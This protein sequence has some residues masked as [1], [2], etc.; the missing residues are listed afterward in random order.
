MSRPAS[1]DQYR[2]EA[3]D[4]AGRVGPSE[5]LGSQVCV[6][7]YAISPPSRNHRGRG[8]KVN[9]SITKA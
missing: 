1:Q 7:G 9:E 8:K 4:L 3:K 6:N 2:T 5:L